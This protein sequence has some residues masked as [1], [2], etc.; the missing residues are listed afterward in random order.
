MSKFEYMLLG[1]LRD[2]C[3]FWL[4]YG[5]RLD[6]YL[7]AGSPQRQIEKMLEIYDGLEDKPEWISRAD[8]LDYAE[9]MGVKVIYVVYRFSEVA[10]RAMLYRSFSGWVDEAEPVATFG[11]KRIGHPE[12]EIRALMDKIKAEGYVINKQREGQAGKYR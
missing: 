5:D 10:T 3:E 1:R 9:R 4:G 7:W 6:K 2:D 11:V 8:I 12:D